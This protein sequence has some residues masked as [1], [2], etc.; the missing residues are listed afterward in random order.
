MQWAGTACRAAA[1]VN[2][3]PTVRRHYEVADSSNKTALRSSLLK[4]L[5]RRF[6]VARYTGG[7]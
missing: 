2:A 1:V 6:V 5:R 4:Q 3:P 7:V